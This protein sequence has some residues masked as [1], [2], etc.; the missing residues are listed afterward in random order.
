MNIIQNEKENGEEQINNIDE[1]NFEN[2]NQTNYIK[3]DINKVDPSVFMPKLL[4]ARLRRRMNIKYFSIVFF[5]YNIILLIIGIFYI[6]ASSFTRKYINDADDYW[7]FY[8]ENKIRNK[9]IPLVFS[10]TGILVIISTSFNIMNGLVILKHIFRGGLRTR[11]SFAIYTTTI[12]Q[13]INFG[14][15]FY[16]II[17]YNQIINLN[18]L[19]LILNG[20]HLVI[21]I[22]LFY[23]T[24]KIISKEDDFMLSLSVLNKHKIDYFNEYERK[25]N[26]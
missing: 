9:E 11:L 4:I 8:F 10:F 26:K 18:I 5:L 22:I 1:E 15:S 17:K 19:L 14:F 23:F 6:D 21:T 16:I 13:A 2:D 20:F 25:L 12:I 7:N 3:L 24:K